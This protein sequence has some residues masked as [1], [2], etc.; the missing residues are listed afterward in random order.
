M[1]RLN[2]IKNFVSIAILMIVIIGVVLIL[3][4]KE[5]QTIKI[6]VIS[7]LTGGN[8]YFGMGVLNGASLAL[9]EADYQISNFKVDLI[10]EDSAGD[11]KTAVTAAQK[12]IN[13]NNVKVIIF[14]DGSSQFLAVAPIAEENKVILFSPIASAE[15]ISEAGDYIFRNREKAN[16]HGA[17][18]AEFVIKQGFKHVSTLYVNAENGITYENYFVERFEELGGVIKSRQ[19]YEKGTADFR[20]RLLKV[21]EEG[22]DALYMPGYVQEMAMIAKQIKELN[23]NITLF[24][25]TGIEDKLYLDIGDAA[26]GTFYTMPEIDTQKENVALFFENYEKKYGNPP[27]YL[28]LIASTNAYDA[29][30]IILITI[31]KCGE[32]ADCIRDNLYETKDYDGVGG[33]IS[34]NDVGDVIKPIIVKTIKNGQ[35]VL[36][37]G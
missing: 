9:E 20:T 3:Q 16:L 37:E 35:F 22:A 21:K 14:G 23:I 13:V 26:E 19:S 7:P 33:L 2:K 30:K 32:D 36:Y 15:K 24:G 17:A 11:S 8:A 4:P 1:K 31:E 29:M 34:F 18:M 6:G 28:E 25:S 27:E 12:L 10:V 5:K